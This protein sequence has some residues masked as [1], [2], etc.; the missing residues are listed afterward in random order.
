MTALAWVAGRAP[1]QGAAMET[2]TEGDGDEGG[3]GVSVE[4][5]ALDDVLDVSSALGL[6]VNMSRLSYVRCRIALHW[7]TRLGVSSLAILNTVTR[8][9]AQTTSDHE[10]EIEAR[11][12]GAAAGGTGH[13]T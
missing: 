13:T 5:D 1:A 9:C 7:F 3:G 11:G 2:E 12:R 10:P 4:M 6:E 8:R